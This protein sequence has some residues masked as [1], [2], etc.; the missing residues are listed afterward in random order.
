MPAEAHVSSLMG[1]KRGSGEEPAL[2]DQQSRVMS[3]SQA[4]VARVLS[5]AICS[6][7]SATRYL[8]A[9]SLRPVCNWPSRATRLLHKQGATGPHRL[10]SRG[11]GRWYAETLS[12][13]TNVSE[14]WL[15]VLIVT[16]SVWHAPWQILIRLLYNHA[17]LKWDKKEKDRSIQVNAEYVGRFCFYN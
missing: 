9:R 13:R 8:D 3:N 2:R 6:A 5:R 16:Q 17:P 15:F 11:S 7:S 12:L 10:W 1:N 14:L 4:A